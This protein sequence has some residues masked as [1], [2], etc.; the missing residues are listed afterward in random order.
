MHHVQYSLHYDDAI[1]ENVKMQL[2]LTNPETQLI[3][4]TLKPRWPR[5]SSAPLWPYGQ[6]Y[7]GVQYLKGRSQRDGARFFSVACSDKITG[8][9]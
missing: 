1:R 6:R 4:N 8:N 2:I 9:G 3:R 5:A 7:P